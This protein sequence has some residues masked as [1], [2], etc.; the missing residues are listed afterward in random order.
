[1]RRVVAFVLDDLRRGGAERVLVRWAGW[2][3]SQGFEV[4]LVTLTAGGPLEGEVASGVA[5][6]RLTAPRVGLAAPPLARYLRRRRPDVVVAT[7]PHVN[8]AASV[9]TAIAG[10]RARLVLREA[11]DPAR[12][13]P[14]VGLAGAVQRP[15]VRWA[16]R[17]ANVVVALTQG[18]AAGLVA[19]LGVRPERIQVIANPSPP[20]A[21]TRAPADGP[22][23]RPR[24]VCVARL[25]PQKDQATL[26]AAMAELPGAALALV[27][28]GLL[29]GALEARVAEAGLSARVRFVGDVGDVGP[30]W[31]WA[32]VAALPSRWEGFPNVLLE[33]LAHGVP[34]VAT[35]CPTG[36]RE[37]LDGG[38]YGALVPV[39]DASALAAA[40]RAVVAA[41]PPPEQRCARAAT[42]DLDVLGARWLE[43]CGLRAAEV[44]T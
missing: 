10:S 18:N 2:F 1:M 11:N 5:R 25:A 34:V 28:D 39:G 6:V 43:A 27:G 19:H 16:Y 17:R 31:A 35:D 4:D 12:E 38:R 24:I 36:P 33:A 7:L 41:P 14:F 40:V 30:W 42:F 15:L 13:H 9:A 22:Q 23:G 26:L 3:A 44:A 20:A 21:P 37:V 32:D 29:R 8:V